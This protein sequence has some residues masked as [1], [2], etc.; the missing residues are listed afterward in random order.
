MHLFFALKNGLQEL[1][2]VAHVCDASK[3]Q[4]EAGDQPELQ[5]KTVSV[6]DDQIN[7]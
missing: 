1:R 7:K 3:W 2:V 6:S 5:S 4:A